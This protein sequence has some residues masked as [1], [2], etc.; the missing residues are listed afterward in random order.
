VRWL[1]VSLAAGLT[2][3]VF[4]RGHLFMIMKSR[5]STTMSVFITSLIFGLLHIFML[6]AFDVMSMVIVVAGGIIAGTM[7]SLIYL[8]TRVIWLAAI[9]HFVW[10]VFFI[11]KIIAITPTQFEANQTIIAFKL[12]THNIVFTGGNFGIESTLP[13]FIVYLIVTAIIFYLYQRKKRR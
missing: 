11:G 5:Y 1:S 2:E 7:F 12:L 10:D 13:S 3:Q 9:V 6:S 8:Y 4:F